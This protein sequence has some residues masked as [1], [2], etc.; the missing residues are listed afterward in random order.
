MLVKYGAQERALAAQRSRQVRLFRRFE[1]LTTYLKEIS[2]VRFEVDAE[3]Y[4][5]ALPKTVRRPDF[6]RCTDALKRTHAAATRVT[7]GLAMARLDV[8]AQ[9]VGHEV[10]FPEPW[11]QFD[12]ARTGM[13]A[14]SLQDIDQV[15]I[16]IDFVQSAS[17]QR[18]LH[19]ADVLGTQFR[20]AEQHAFRLSKGLDN[21][22]YPRSTIMQGLCVVPTISGI[23]AH[24][25]RNA[26]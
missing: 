16:R 5:P 9:K 6:F 23:T 10:F 15:V 21:R 24:D 3:D 2:I 8:R 14:N 17:G 1:T 25:R 4:D 7:C 19:D 20:P 12:D 22:S 13:L 26:Q 11:R 18:A